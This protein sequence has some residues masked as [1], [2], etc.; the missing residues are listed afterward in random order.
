M[1]Y[2]SCATSWNESCVIVEFILV[3]R[4]SSKRGDVHTGRTSVTVVREILPQHVV[5]RIHLVCP[6]AITCFGE[7]LNKLGTV[8]CKQMMNSSKKYGKKCLHSEK[9]WRSKDYETFQQRWNSTWGMAEDI[10]MT[11]CRN[12]IKL[13]WCSFRLLKW[14]VNRDVIFCVKM[15]RFIIIIIIIIIGM[16]VVLLGLLLLLLVVVVV[17]MCIRSCKQWNS[18]C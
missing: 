9:K 10:S 15:V 13:L 18:F 14:K 8:R 5:L 3:P 6:R 4:G 2:D 7:T 11:C 12:E 16:V 17:V 1:F